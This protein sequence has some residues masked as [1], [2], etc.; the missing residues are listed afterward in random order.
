VACNDD[1]TMTECLGTPPYMCTVLFSSTSSR[2]L[3][4]FVY[5]VLANFLS[6]GV[7]STSNIL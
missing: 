1:F 3:D 4:L 5:W 6:T 7:G 2:L